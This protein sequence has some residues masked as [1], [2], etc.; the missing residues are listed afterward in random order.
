MISAPHLIST[1]TGR[2]QAIGQGCRAFS[3]AA[4]SIIIK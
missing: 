1:K 4:M 3:F 2:S